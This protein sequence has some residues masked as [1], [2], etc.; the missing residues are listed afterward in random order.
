MDEIE[1]ILLEFVDVLICSPEGI[2]DAF[3]KL[4]NESEVIDLRLNHHHCI[5]VHADIYRPTRLDH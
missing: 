1:Q 4:E 2:M 3:E 5:L